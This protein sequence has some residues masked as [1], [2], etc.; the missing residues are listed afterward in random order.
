MSKISSH[1]FANSFLDKK[2]IQQAINRTKSA[3]VVSAVSEIEKFRVQYQYIKHTSGKNDLLCAML[4]VSKITHIE[5]KKLPVDERLCWGDVL[6]RRQEQTKNLQ[7]FIEKNSHELGYE[8]P[9][10]LAE[11]CGIFVNLTQPT[12]VARDKYLQIHCEV[13]EAKLRGELPSIFEYVW[14]RVMNNP[15]ATQADA[16]K[17]IAL[18]RLADENSITPDIFHSSRWLIIREELGII[19]AQWINSGTPVKSWQGIVLLQALWDMGIIY[20]G[21]QLAQSLFHKAGDFRRDEKTALKVII[22]T[23]EQYNDARQYGPVFTAKDTE[24]E[25]FRCYNTIVLKGLQNESNPEKLHQLTRGLVDVLTE[26]AEKRFE[27]FSSALLC[28]IT[29]KFPPLSDTSDG[30]DLSANKAYF[31]LREKLSHH[32]KIESFLLEL[33]KSNNIR[34]FQSRIK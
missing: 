34:K 27:G 2:L 24:N 32:E 22:K 3:R 19:A 26:G 30:I 17:V 23:F 18:H 13:E 10:D 5:V 16:Y 28:L 7:S 31:S 11:Q 1:P 21:S 9:V 20:A 25:L 29:P 8:V 15:E 4:G 6:K 14:S 12:A 33:A